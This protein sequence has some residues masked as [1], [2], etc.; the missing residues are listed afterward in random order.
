MT[1]TLFG[2]WQ[3]RIFL[4][5]T[6]G[7]IFSLPFYFGFLGGHEGDLSYF[8]VVIYVAIFGFFWDILYDYLQKILWD[9]DWP[10][11]LQFLA[12]VLEGFFLFLVIILIGLPGIKSYQFDLFV[13]IK[14]YSLVWLAIYLSSW[15][16][17]RLLFPRWRFCGGEWLGKWT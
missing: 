11:V 16:I 3:T 6:I 5:A 15:I 7:V 13:F 12:G 1:P 9:H 17:M 8:F 4:L 2:R 10:G 14:H